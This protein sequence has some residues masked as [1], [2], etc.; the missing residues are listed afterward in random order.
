[1]RATANAPAARVTTYSPL[2]HSWFDQGVSAVHPPRSRLRRI[3]ATLGVDRG[4]A[5]TLLALLL[6]VGLLLIGAHLVTKALGI[7]EYL[8]DLGVDRG[9]GEFF[10]YVMTLWT[11]LLLGALGFRRRAGVF[12]AWAL[13]AGYLGIDD[14]LSIHE[15]AGFA[16]AALAPQMG[17]A[18]VHIGELL[19]LG[20]VGLILVTAVAVAHLRA[21]RDDRAVSGILILLFA[22]LAFFGIAIDAIH[23]LLLPGPTFDVIG[24]TIEDGGEILVMSVIFSFVFAVW[25]GHQPQLSGPAARLVGR[26]AVTQPTFAPPVGH[27]EATEPLAPVGTSQ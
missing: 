22:L 19:W 14:A 26:T 12:F 10:Q 7:T 6:S 1:M 3:S 9:Y 25:S 4:P 17:G 11:V 16:F 15:R 8:L 5:A 27:P 18:A 20:G 23:H 21:S 24:T 2:R 13:A